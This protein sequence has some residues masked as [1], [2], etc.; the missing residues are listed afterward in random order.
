MKSPSPSVLRLRLSRLAIHVALGLGFFVSVGLGRGSLQSVRAPDDTAQDPAQDPLRA[1]ETVKRKLAVGSSHNYRID[2]EA[3]EFIQIDL[4]PRG[5]EVGIALSG[6]GGEVLA[7]A[8]N[9]PGSPHSERL[10]AIAEDSGAHCVKVRSA[11][12]E[13]ASGQYELKVVEV[14]IAIARDVSRV[15]AARTL[16]QGERLCDEAT[17]A[18]LPKGMEQ[19]EDALRLWRLS[20]DV[21]GESTTL[22]DIGWAHFLMGD[23]TK[24][25]E[26]FLEALPLAQAAA[27][28]AGEAHISNRIGTAYDA[29]GEK[30]RSIGYYERARGIY[31][32]LAS[33]SGE[34]TALNNL[35][36]VY[37]DIGEK[38]NAITHLKQALPLWAAAG[39]RFGEASTCNVLGAVYDT[40]GDKTPALEYYERALRLRR[41]I[42]DSRGVGETL[43]NMGDLFAWT[44]D[45]QKAF[46]SYGA[47]LAQ[48][49]EGGSRIDEARTLGD[50]GALYVSLGDFDKALEY[51]EQALAAERAEKD[52]YGEADTLSSAAEALASLG[53]TQRAIDYLRSALEL[54]KRVDDVPEQIHTLNQL[55]KVCSA[56]G[57]LSDAY[58]SHQQA[59]ALARSV[60][61]RPSEAEAM[62]GLAAIDLLRGKPRDVVERLSEAAA[63]SRAVGDRP[64]EA[65]SLYLMARALRAR[66]DLDLALNAIERCLAIVESLRA[67]L[68]AETLRTSYFASVSEKYAFWVDLLMR[69]H[70]RDPSHGFDA[71]AFEA[72]ERA[73]ARSLLE[74]LAE[75]HADIRQGV[76]PT[77]RERE[78]SL[79]QKVTAAR[80]RQTHVLSGPH[81]EEEAAALEKEIAEREAEYDALEAQVRLS[82]PVYGSLTQPKPLTAPQVQQRLLDADTVLLEY[83]LG[84]ERS[85]LWA[86]TS[87]EVASFQLPKR[88]EIESAA[89]RVYEALRRPSGK[90]TEAKR[91]RRESASLSEIVLGPAKRFLSHERLAI[92]ADGALQYIPFE[93]LPSPGPATSNGPESFLVAR[94]EIVNLPSASALDV[95]RQEFGGRA[96]APR[97]LAVLADPV[98]ERGDRRVRVAAGKRSA[99]Q[100]DAGRT[101]AVRELTRSVGDVSDKGTTISLTRL[102]FTRQEAAAL[103]AL[104][105]PGQRMRALDFDANRMTV[106]SGDLSQ[107]RF[108]HFATHGILDTAHPQ[109]SG[110]VFSLVDPA[111]NDQNGYLSAA[112]AFNLKL[113]ADLVVLSAC[114]TALGKEIRGEGLVGLTR[115]FMYAG[116][117]RV[118]ASLWRVDDVA[119]AELMKRFYQGMLGRQKLR[120][121]AALHE[122]QL[123]MRKQ[124][125]WRDPFY[126]AGFV[127]QGEWR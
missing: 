114:R 81:E 13:G 33:P 63:L 86:V 91:A 31:G 77:L 23:K 67:T 24:A 55:G 73:R 21:L 44:G 113:S 119:T 54:E 108:V 51:Q 6:P 116:A 96:P 92:V 111:G 11:G 17:A 82:S 32:A 121:A 84:D 14:R 9:F 120:P 1:G 69:L 27:D 10:I 7:E 42:H 50:T 25:L 100:V 20:E 78:R 30:R 87:D 5:L 16:R 93:A 101:V 79:Q 28:R 104:A 26:Y 4:I 64:N 107:Y 124:A 34:A 98:F 68:L 37:D 102:P 57:R 8:E 52:P 35:G 72:S 109:L 97:T 85:Y 105:S 122:A 125:R 99:P 18:S 110:L 112:D 19:L 56:A 118:V 90:R 127:L 41:E 123:A 61:N 117:P 15:R 45:L 62:A 75:A 94:H 71:L 66:G 48:A 80:M 88:S 83:A 36:G 46:D 40:L 103:F 70:E 126:W 12:P 95:L 58:A 74:L 2:L 49:R 65:T 47:A 22:A 89:R 39:D 3:G 106:T 43:R 76:D 29:L 38:Q 53:H 60:G 59:L 115:A